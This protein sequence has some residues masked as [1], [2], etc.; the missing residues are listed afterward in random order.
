MCSSL[1][2]SGRIFI[3]MTERGFKLKT[4]NTADE[5]TGL[6]SHEMKSG[7]LSCDSKSCESDVVRGHGCILLPTDEAL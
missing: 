2:C 6:N 4:L 3:S 5:I 7:R 1:R